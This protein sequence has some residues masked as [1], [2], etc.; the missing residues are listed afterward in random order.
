[1]WLSIPLWSR[2]SVTTTVSAAETTT[3]TAAVSATTTTVAATETTT[4]AATITTAAATVTR[5]AWWTTWF[6]ILWIK[7]KL[8][9]TCCGIDTTLSIDFGDTNRHHITQL[10]IFVWP[11]WWCVTELRD[12]DEGITASANLNK[13]TEL[14]EACDT[15]LDDITR[16]HQPGHIFDNLAGCIATCAISCRDVNRAILLDVNLRTCF[17]TDLLDVLAAWADDGTDL[18]RINLQRDDT[19]SI[20]GHLLTWSTDGL[21]DLAKDVQAGFECL[22]KAFDKDITGNPLN[23]CVELQ[24]GD[25]L[26]RTSDLEV[27]ITGKVF[28]SLDISKD[29]VLTGCFIADQTHCNTRD[30][31]LD[32]N[33]CIEEC[34]G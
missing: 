4:V 24:G 25:A 30:R 8:Q 26:S 20:F 28:H 14:Q 22:G 21:I 29:S 18:L 33:A 9:A 10:E 2:T 1:M 27:H 7:R 17:S 5:R 16:L 6:R 32:R 19:W 15:T 11:R 31:C 13:R 23:L 3:V 34:E 12:V